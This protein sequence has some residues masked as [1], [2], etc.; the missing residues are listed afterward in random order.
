MGKTINGTLE[1]N[2]YQ[3]IFSINVNIPMLDDSSNKEA[4]DQRDRL[5]LFN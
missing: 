2:D 1:E 4:A 5:F 3:D